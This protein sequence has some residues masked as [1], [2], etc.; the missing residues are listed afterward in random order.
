MVGIDDTHGTA[1]LA[2]AGISVCR[3]VELHLGAIKNNSGLLL[4]VVITLI[5]SD[6]AYV[7]EVCRT[8]DFNLG[9]IVVILF[10]VQSVNRVAAGAA[11]HIARNATI[12]AAISVRIHTFRKLALIR[13]ASNGHVAVG[14]IQP[15]KE[16]AGAFFGAELNGLVIKIKLAGLNGHGTGIGASKRHIADDTT[17]IRRACI[18]DLQRRLD[19]RI[20]VKRQGKVRG[21]ADKAAAC[22]FTDDRKPRKINGGAKRHHR[23]TSAITD[24][25]PRAF[26]V[27]RGF[28]HLHVAVIRCWQIKFLNRKRSAVGQRVRQKTDVVGAPLKVNLQ[29]QR[30]IRSIRGVNGHNSRNLA[31]QRRCQPCRYGLIVGVVNRIIDGYGRNK[32]LLISV[33]LFRHNRLVAVRTRPLDL[34]SIVLARP[35]HI[36]EERLVRRNGHIGKVIDSFK[37]ICVI[38]KTP[39]RKSVHGLRDIKTNARATAL[40]NRCALV[41]CRIR[42]GQ[43]KQVFIVTDLDNERLP[44]SG[45]ITPRKDR[46]ELVK[47]LVLVVA[48]RLSLGRTIIGCRLVGGRLIRAFGIIRRRIIGRLLSLLRIPGSCTRSVRRIGDSGILTGACVGIRNIRC[49][50]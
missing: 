8:L 23:R 11:A 31:E 49:V 26:A 29:R 15:A 21:L 47:R 5:A 18:A 25:G 27:G 35:L 1:E 32:F 16:A 36:I 2:V 34:N 40:F 45:D 20:F 28:D 41:N 39:K 24:Q 12:T 46:L 19:A 37:R 43:G 9:F 13:A 14:E 50:H 42:I 38:T 17:G 7:T 3:A 10:D 33:N 48:L 22:L 4:C 6:T 44:L 30:I